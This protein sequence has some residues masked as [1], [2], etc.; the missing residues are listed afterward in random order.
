MP[1]L[2]ELKKFEQALEEVQTKDQFLMVLGWLD[3]YDEISNEDISNATPFYTGKTKELL[4]WLFSYQDGVFRKDVLMH[5]LALHLSEQSM[6][7]YY[8]DYFEFGY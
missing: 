1:T 8:H 5:F 4:Y 6:G 3:E 2:Q 7:R